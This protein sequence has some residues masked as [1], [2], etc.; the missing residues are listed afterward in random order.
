[1]VPFVMLKRSHLPL[2]PSWDAWVIR[3]SHLSVLT[4]DQIIIMMTED[5]LIYN[6][7]YIFKEQFTQ[8]E[9]SC[10]LLTLFYAL[11]TCMPYFL[12]WSTKGK[13]KTIIWLFNVLFCCLAFI[14]LKTVGTIL[15]NI[16]PICVLR[17]KLNP[18][19]SWLFV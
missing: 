8:N 5:G 11:Q 16:S 17:K 10:H 3:F 1:M 13:H 15:F 4:K 7:P 6:I 19:G 2:L 18:C 9:N 12:L 14:I